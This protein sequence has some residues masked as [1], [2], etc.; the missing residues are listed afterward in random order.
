MANTEARPL[1]L[2]AMEIE[3]DWKRVNYAARPYLEAMHT[4]ETVNDYFGAD[5]GNEIVLYFLANAGT[6]RGE[7]A[8]RVK[9]E[10]KA[11]VNNP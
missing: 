11:L 10:L 6:W 3:S 2:I 4:L 8:R 1:W 9:A 5:P 7:T